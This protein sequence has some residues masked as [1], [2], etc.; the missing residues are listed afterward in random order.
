L[1]TTSLSSLSPLQPFVIKAQFNNLI[2]NFTKKQWKY[3]FKYNLKYILKYN[4][5]YNKEGRI[6]KAE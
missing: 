5:K 2:I 3:N 1:R 4:L 6:E